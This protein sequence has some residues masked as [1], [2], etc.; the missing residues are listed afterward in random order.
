MNLQT[1]NI[2]CSEVGGQNCITIK[3]ITSIASYARLLL[4]IMAEVREHRTPNG[5]THFF[6]VEELVDFQF[7]FKD[8]IIMT[9]MQG[10]SRQSGWSGFGQTN[11]KT[12]FN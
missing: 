10:R 9:S 2:C 12:G 3:L 11:F 1:T 6:D 7:L 4:A 5:C 8:F